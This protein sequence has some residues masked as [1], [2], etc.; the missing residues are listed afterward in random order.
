MN[1]VDLYQDLQ[2]NQYFDGGAILYQ[3]MV[4]NLKSKTE[5]IQILDNICLSHNF[6]TLNEDWEEISIASFESLLHKALHY[7]IGFLNH[8]IMPI[9]K[10]KILLQIVDKEFQS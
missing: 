6:R 3:S 10:I 9:E 7:N 8:E 4:I 5:V 1:K 2:L